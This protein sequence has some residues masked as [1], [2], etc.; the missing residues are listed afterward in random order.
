MLL[1][2]QVIAYDN[3]K[4]E[5]GSKS[6]ENEE[7]RKN[8]AKDIGTQVQ[9]KY[10]DNI[11]N[12]N[13]DES[14]ETMASWHISQSIPKPEKVSKKEEQQQIKIERKRLKKQKK[15]CRKLQRS[16]KK[17]KLQPYTDP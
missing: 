13:Y 11:S 5:K 1:A 9:L 2:V 4:K 10:S 16:R 12:D 6:D 15:E 7:I 8:T 17:D 3:D 14:V